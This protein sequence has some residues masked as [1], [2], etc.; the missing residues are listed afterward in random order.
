[1]G[2]HG[3]KKARTS[4]SPANMMMNPMMNPM[5]QAMALHPMANM[6]NMM[7]PMAMM[8]MGQQQGQESSS[9]DEDRHHAAAK[10]AGFAPAPLQEQPGPPPPAVPDQ[11]GQLMNHQAHA[12]EALRNRRS[13]LFSSTGGADKKIHRGA[14]MIRSLPKD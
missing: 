1:M 6:M 4:A 5:M 9:E 7:N 3:A 12:F 8:G 11:Q 10:A 2:R 14:A 13:N